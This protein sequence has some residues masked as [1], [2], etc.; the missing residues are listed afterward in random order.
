[1][2]ENAPEESGSDLTHESRPWKGYS[3]MT[4]EYQIASLNG[5]TRRGGSNFEMTWIF[6]TI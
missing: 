4:S 5:P 6:D 1:M 2:P 3:G